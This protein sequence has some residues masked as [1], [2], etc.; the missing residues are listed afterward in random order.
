M[1]RVI[2]IMNQKGGVGKTTTSLNLAHAL[3]KSGKHVLLLDT[4]P[5]AHL[6]ASFGMHGLGMSGM[7]SVLLD[8]DGI[9]DVC[10]EVREGLSL[11]P[12]GDRLGELEFISAGGASRGYRLSH[13]IDESAQD[14]DYILIDCPPS[15]G[16][17]GMNCLL[18]AKELLIPVSSDYLALHGLSRLMSIINNIES[19]LNRDTKKWLVVTRYQ[20]RRRLARGVLEKLIRYFPDQVLQ[21]LIRETVS[22]AESPGFGKTIF[23]YR[24]SS[25]GA[26]D[27]LSLALDLMEGR[28]LHEYETEAEAV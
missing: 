19:R 15:T 14:W 17:L 16:L 7:D 23:D 5:Q 22:L 25:H 3:A 21:T 4:D 26:E 20:H 10:M 1:T 12:A 8:G 6:S 2:A 27:Y 24:K 13:A 11:V 18:A 9:D 28:V